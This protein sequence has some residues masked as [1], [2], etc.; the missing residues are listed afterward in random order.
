VPWL[1]PLGWLGHAVD[2]SPEGIGFLAE[3]SPRLGSVLALQV[4][5]GVPGASLT[6]VAR[7]IHCARGEDG[8][9]R[10]GCSVSPPFSNE[11]V[12]SLL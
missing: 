7:V 8:C 10:V 1:D 5:C 3:H 12:A 2:V 6:R 9:W 4:L 11:E